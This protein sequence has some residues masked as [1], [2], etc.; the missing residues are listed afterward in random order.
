MKLITQR[1]D[2]SWTVVERNGSFVATVYLD[3]ELEN[4]NAN[5]KSETEARDYVLAFLKAMVFD[6]A[7]AR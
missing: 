2:V 6:V 3:D 5:C 1:T 4:Q 7:N